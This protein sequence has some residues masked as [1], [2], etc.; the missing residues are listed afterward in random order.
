MWR[1]HAVIQSRTMKRKFNDHY[2]YQTIEEFE[3]VTF[4][5][6]FWHAGFQWALIIFVPLLIVGENIPGSDWRRWVAVVGLGFMFWLV[7]VFLHEINENVRFVRHQLRAYRDAVHELNT[8]LEQYQNR[9]NFKIADAL[10]Y[11]DRKWERPLK[12]PRE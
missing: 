10:E 12:E 5:D 2:Y 9:E 8:V 7:L 4:K 11:L 1:S 6:R 3:D